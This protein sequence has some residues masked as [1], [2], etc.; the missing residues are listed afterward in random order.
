M[1]T[2]FILLILNATLFAGHFEC[3][4]F[5]EE[6]YRPFFVFSDKKEGPALGQGFMSS[7]KECE[8]AVAVANNEYGV[9][10]SRT[11]LNGW[12][13]T[14]Y[15]GTSPGRADFGYMG[16]SSIMKFEDCLTATKYSSKKGVC[17]WGAPGWYISRID[18]ESSLGG[19]Y[20][21]IDECVAQTKEDAKK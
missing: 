8:S 6:S 2:T 12:K 3:K 14:L 9:V 20:G 19:G 5:G 17:Y 7:L 1:K 13:P 18:R 21:T 10:C 16:G 11:G 4:K 15:T